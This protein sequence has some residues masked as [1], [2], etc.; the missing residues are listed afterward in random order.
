MEE[1]AKAMLELYE[2]GSIRAIGTSNFSVAQVG[3]SVA[4]PHSTRC[5]RPHVLRRVKR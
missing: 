1:T 2:Q 5:N 4:S 3:R